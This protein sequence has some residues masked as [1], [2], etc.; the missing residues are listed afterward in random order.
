MTEISEGGD[1]GEFPQEWIPEDLAALP[2]ASFSVDKPRRVTWVALHE[3][4]IEFVA[5]TPGATGNAV[6]KAI[7]G[8][9]ADVFQGLRA[10]NKANRIDS[11]QH[12]RSVRWFL[13]TAS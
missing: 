10:L 2:A 3:R 13:S 6:A 4:I 7:K 5:Q 8:R 9:R 12:G 11:V 1:E